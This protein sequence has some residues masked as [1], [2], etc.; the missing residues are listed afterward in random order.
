MK[1]NNY[2][3][4]LTRVIKPAQYLGSEVNSIRKDEKDIK[5]RIALTFPDLY[6]VGMSHLGLSILYHILNGRSGVAA[7]RVYAPDMDYAGEL[8]K[9][10]LPLASL[11]TQTPLNRFDAV[12]FTLQYELSYTNILFILHLAKIPLRS[13]DRG[14]DDPILIGGGPCAFNPEPLAMLFD[15]FV[16]GDGEEAIVEIVDILA[17][18]KEEGW[19]RERTLKTLSDLDGVYVP[20]FFHPNYHEDGYIRDIVP[21]F[22]EKTFVLKRFLKD[23]NGV[24][25]PTKPPIPFTQL[26]HNRLS[27]EIDRGCTQGCRFCQAGI[28]YRP[29]RERSWEKIEDLLDKSLTSTGYEEFSL[30]SLS[31]GDFSCIH[32]LAPY[33]LSKYRDRRTALSFPS[34]RPG[35]IR[36]EL[37]ES[38]RS[39]R[40]TGF[41]VSVE[42]GTERLRKVINK[43]IS[44]DDVMR[45]VSDLGSLGW[46]R[47][48]FYFMIGLPTETMEDIREIHNFCMRVSKIVNKKGSRLKGINLGIGYFVPKAHTP[49]QWVPQDTLEV[50]QEK[51]GLLWSLFRSRRD[52]T[53]KR[54]NAQASLLEGVFAKG[55]RRLGSVVEKAF[56][57]GRRFDG[58]GERFRYDLWEKA[59]K[60]VGIDP[61]FY[62]H[63]KIPLEEKLPWSHIKTGVSDE[64][65]KKEYL[66]AMEETSTEDCR[67]G[68]CH[69]CGLESSCKKVVAPTVWTGE[70]TSP[71]G[72]REPDSS[73][74]SMTMRIR[75]K[76]T[77]DMKYIS[78]LD[79][80]R[81]LHRSCI[82]MGFP[83]SY[84]EG[85]HPH[86]KIAY[87]SA[88][89][90]GVESYAEYADIQFFKPV[91]P[92]DFLHGINQALPE[93]LKA[94]SAHRLLPMAR[95]LSNS[96]ERVDYE[97]SVHFNADEGKIF[98]V[99]EDLEKAVDALLGAQEIVLDRIRKGKPQTIN[100]SPFIKQL[101]LMDF[102][103]QGFRLAVTLA[104]VDSKQVQ[105]LDVLRKLV[106]SEKLEELEVDVVKT[107]T[108][109]CR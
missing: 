15:L 106:D 82:R 86:P 70:R 47:L 102:S 62:A 54:P 27:L 37:M 91:E 33:L 93:G 46:E 99:R 74:L 5:V 22:P 4:I 12:G 24:D 81:L 16:V 29:V 17:L 6:E 38:I 69:L 9:R 53:L 75:F 52:F 21:K 31:S 59:F 101:K 36:R 14:E 60:E 55:D 88:L 11:E 18:A 97:V 8:E 56:E 100:L 65:L 105:P 48:K 68:K 87:S 50:L 19:K 41:T 20:S 72:T 89:S 1:K 104:V 7:E 77:G 109:F 44:E 2:G 58:W 25:Y 51:M 10:G 84:S 107:E 43:N 67:Y 45:T 96:V 61:S 13:V 34:L 103:D 95:S 64:Y 92:D 63:R 39:A 79:L 30:L 26:I 35:T 32:E 108:H 76:K 42:A 73:F 66:G 23:L 49:F 83:L 85:F 3:K 40:K 94:L 98:G 80:N 90:L 78:H 71:E 57:L 28:I